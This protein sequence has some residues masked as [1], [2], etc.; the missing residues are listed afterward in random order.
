MFL[1]WLESEFSVAKWKCERMIVD[2]GIYCFWSRTDEELSLVCP[3]ELLPKDVE[4]HEDG[5][6]GFRIKGQMDFTLVGILAEI[7]RCLAEK[8][9]SIFAV[10]TYDT[11][12]IF[13]KKRYIDLAQEV[14]EAD[15][16]HFI[17]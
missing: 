3:T 7:S 16:W 6:V 4:L 14:L 13:I 10:S 17:N 2:L 11:D 9:I 8:G 5:W 15:N 12:Y 1:E